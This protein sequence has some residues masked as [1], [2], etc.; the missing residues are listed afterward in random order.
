[1]GDPGAAYYVLDVPW[2]NGR[3]LT[4]L[5]LDERGAVL[6]ALDLTPPLQRVVRLTDPKPCSGRATRAGRA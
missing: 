3:D 4:P 2:L 5:T 1:M 6:D